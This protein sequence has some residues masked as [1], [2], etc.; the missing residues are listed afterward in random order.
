MRMMMEMIMPR[1]GNPGSLEL[2]QVFC[3]G[4][5]GR[6]QGLSRQKK[7]RSGAAFLGESEASQ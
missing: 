7:E 3:V 2:C 6:Q 4:C 5:V 1:P